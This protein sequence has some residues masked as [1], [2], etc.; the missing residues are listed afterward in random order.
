MQELIVFHRKHETILKRHGDNLRAVTLRDD[1]S[2]VVERAASITALAKH[3]QKPRN[4]YSLSELDDLARE[5][6][7]WLYEAVV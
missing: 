5:Q 3:L 4:E 2:V 6:G 7:I 1:G